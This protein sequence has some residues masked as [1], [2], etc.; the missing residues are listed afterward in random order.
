[1]LLKAALTVLVFT[2]IG[3][4]AIIGLIA[5]IVL[6]ATAAIVF[7]EWRMNREKKNRPPRLSAWR[8]RSIEDR[9]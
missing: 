9:E 7:E 4:V 5:L 2:V 8:K 6:G 3:A 1:M